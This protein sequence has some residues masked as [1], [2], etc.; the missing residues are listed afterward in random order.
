MQNFLNENQETYLRTDDDQF[1]FTR[2]EGMKN[3]RSGVKTNFLVRPKYQDQTS[4][5][6]HIPRYGYLSQVVANI[7]L[8]SS[9]PEDPQE[10]L[11][12]RL[13]E[14]ITLQ[15]ERGPFA[16]QTLNGHY[17]N[18]R[19]Q[20]I[21]LLGQKILNGI[22]SDSFGT[23]YLPLFFF[24]SEST[25]RFINTETTE[26]LQIKFNLNPAPMYLLANQ[27]V[28]FSITL[29]CEF[30]KFGYPPIMALLPSKEQTQLMTNIQAT[31]PFFY[32][33]DVLLQCPADIC[34]IHFFLYN[35]A[36]A[37]YYPIDSY[38]LSALDR[39]I[40]TVNTYTDYSLYVPQVLSNQDIIKSYVIGT[41]ID[42]RN[43]NLYFNLRN[44][45]L[46]LTVIST[47]LPAGYY[48]Y[49]IYEYY[50]W[51]RLGKTVEVIY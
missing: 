24:F 51:V 45:N 26:R 4:Q 30:Y 1:D 31:D 12:L 21:G 25:D 8:V 34:A 19:I 46:Y 33:S 37:Q 36:T 42:R 28:S 6:F 14:S 23:Y 17:L 43:N 5:I 27:L 16:I 13:F 18:V 20:N 38:T 49:V 48:L 44:Q 7:K 50:Q 35:P 3:Y 22:D 41:Q 32:F 2:Y 10:R 39:D 47:N 15:T 9:G 11:P 29:T 40:T